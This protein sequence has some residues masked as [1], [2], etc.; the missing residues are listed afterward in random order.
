MIWDKII[1]DIFRLILLFGSRG[2]IDL[3]IYSRTVS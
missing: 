2:A 1:R 3:L